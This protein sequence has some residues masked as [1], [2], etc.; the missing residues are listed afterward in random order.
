MAD[1][2]RT[3][4]ITRDDIERRL[5]ALQGDLADTGESIK[6]YAI[7]AGAVVAVAAIAL[8]FGFGRRRGHKRQTIVEVRRF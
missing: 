2:A 8:A 7:A 3:T 1:P 5:R 6:H 4:P